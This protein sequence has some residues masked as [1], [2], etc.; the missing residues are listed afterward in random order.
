MKKI[1]LVIALSMTA[2]L[3]SAQSEKFVKAMEQKL[4]GYDTTRNVEGLQEFANSFERIA[5]AE[6]TQWL[7]YYYAAMSNVNLGY[8]HVMSAGPMG[9]NADKADPLADK[10]ELLINKAEALSKD[11]SEIYVVKKNDR[12]PENDGRCDE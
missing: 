7:P 5:E 3:M 11:N 10:A 9:G 8:K 4:V 6:K 1:V 12:L 2:G